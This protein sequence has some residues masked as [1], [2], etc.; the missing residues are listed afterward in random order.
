MHI[1]ELQESVMQYGRMRGKIEETMEEI[2][3]LQEIRGPIGS[4][5]KNRRRR[6]LYLSDFQAG[7]PAS[8]E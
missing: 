5:K 4:M 6:R 3:Y 8:A 7:N 2:G 1:E